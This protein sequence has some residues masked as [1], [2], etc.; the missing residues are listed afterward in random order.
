SRRVAIP[1]RDK[2]RGQ[3]ETPDRPAARP[4]LPYRAGAPS[5]ANAALRLGGG[6]GVWPP[7]RSAR[8]AP[9]YTVPGPEILRQGNERRTWGDPVPCARTPARASDHPGLARRTAPSTVRTPACRRPIRTPWAE[10]SC[11]GPACR[12]SLG[13]FGLHAVNKLASLCHG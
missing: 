12:R 4:G 10:L 11:L 5:S 6:P 3:I 9:R 8:R 2:R 7:S 13:P 1:I